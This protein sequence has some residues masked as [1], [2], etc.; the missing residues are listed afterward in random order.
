MLS[1]N[2]LNFS[3][4]SSAQ[5]SPFLHIFFRVSVPF[6]GA[7]K[8]PNIAPAAMPA[9]TPNATFPESMI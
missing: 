6:A 8:I 2:S 3:F 1:R 5:S 9:N 4:E 7:N